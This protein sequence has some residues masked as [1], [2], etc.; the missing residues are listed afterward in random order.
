[1]GC[2][3]N[4]TW[5]YPV[6]LGDT[7]EKVQSKLGKPMEPYESLSSH[8]KKRNIEGYPDS[9]VSVEYDDFGRVSEINF[10][11]DYHQAKW[12]TS[13]SEI[14]YGITLNMDKDRIYKIL[15][16][17]NEIEQ[18][19]TRESREYIWFMSDLKINIEFWEK[20]YVENDI[21]YPKDSIRFLSI[22]KVIN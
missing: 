5:D 4:K 13:K 22:K 10:V 11:G 7:K 21:K 20:D 2:T 18:L 12:R 16:K 14:L 8:M 9:G 19:I 1:M 6:C 17:P 3:S 15:G